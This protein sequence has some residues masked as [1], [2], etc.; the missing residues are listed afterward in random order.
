MTSIALRRH[1]A[2]GFGKGR[3]ALIPRAIKRVRAG[4][5]KIHAAIAAAKIR[6]LRNELMYNCRSR[7]RR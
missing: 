1:A 5:R 6:R 4:L 7:P 2:R 3:A